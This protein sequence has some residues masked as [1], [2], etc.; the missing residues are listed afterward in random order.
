M[1]MS[2]NIVFVIGAGASK[3]VGLPTGLELKDTIA[4][5]LNIKFEYGVKQVSGDYLIKESLSRH[6]NKIEGPGKSIDE[7]LHAA[8]HIVDALP[9]AISID[10]FI[11]TQRGNDKISLCGKLAI[12]RSILQSEKRSL[13][14]FEPPG[15]PRMSMPRLKHTWYVQLFQLLSES[16]NKDEFKDRL[17]KLHLSYLTMTGVLNIFF[18]MVY[19]II[20]KPLMER[21]SAH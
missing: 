16:C 5:L 18:I 6:V 4:Q 14:Y 8:Y 13:L 15:S 20:I 11:D 12:V 21:R 17:K 7:Y 1:V 9:Q 10:N 19:K 3:E 2:E